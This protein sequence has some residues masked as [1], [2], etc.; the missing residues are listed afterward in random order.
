MR[1]LWAICGALVLVGCA[2]GRQVGDGGIPADAAREETALCEDANSPTVCDRARALLAPCIAY[3]GNCQNLDRGKWDDCVKVMFVVYRNLER[4]DP[5][6]QLGM[7]TA[8]VY[9]GY[10]VQWADCC[11]PAKQATGAG[12]C[13]GRP[14]G[15]APLPGG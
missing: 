7:A 11:K 6:Q 3:H 4:C 12:T 10:K 14:D 13:K 8:L 5:R 1:R 15:G 2:P 9:G